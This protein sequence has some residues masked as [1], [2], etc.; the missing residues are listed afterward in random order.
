MS[1]FN[2]VDDKTLVQ[3]AVD[4]ILKRRQFFPHR[5][6]ARTEIIAVLFDRH[7]MFTKRV[8][9]EF[10]NTVAQAVGGTYTVKHGDSRIKW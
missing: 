2:T 5:S 10:M 6:I 7:A 8:T 1:T 3:S 9:R 4:Y